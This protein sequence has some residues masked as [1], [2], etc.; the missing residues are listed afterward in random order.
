MLF[1][2]YIFVFF[3]LDVFSV[4]DNIDYRETNLD[5]DP[6]RKYWTR[7]RSSTYKDS[8]MHAYINH[9]DVKARRLRTCP[10]CSKSRYSLCAHA[11]GWF[12]TRIT[13]LKWLERQWRGVWWTTSRV[14]CC[15]KGWPRSQE[16][17]KYLLEHALNI[18]VSSDEL[19]HTDIRPRTDFVM[20]HTN[21][22]HQ[23]LHEKDAEFDKR[24]EHTLLV[25][26][27]VGETFL[28]SKK[29]VW[30]THTGPSA[31]SWAAWCKILLCTSR[32]YYDWY[33]NLSWSIFCSY[34][35][36]KDSDKDYSSV[37]AVRRNRS[38]IV[39]RLLGSL[40][41]ADAFHRIMIWTSH[42]KLQWTCNH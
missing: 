1:A 29:S 11:S 28:Y 3:T 27:R 14:E 19:R 33:E 5:I 42:S 31:C 39:Q 12:P 38:G 15:P 13:F 4:S 10:W 36:Y 25:W 30:T 40:I 8:T 34:A 23:N 6:H 16:G 32:P 37:F 20:R 22:S 21:P 26:S 17:S 18:H 41:R 7:D 9:H 24:F 2:C 35:C